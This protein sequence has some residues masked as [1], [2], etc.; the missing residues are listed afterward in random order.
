[1]YRSFTVLIHFNNG[2]YLKIHLEIC[3]VCFTVCTNEH[4]VKARRHID[5]TVVVNKKESSSS[6]R[7]SPLLSFNV[8]PA[9]LFRRKDVFKCRRNTEK[10]E[11]ISQPV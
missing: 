11:Y 2:R 7:F 10:G 5:N 4:F 6:D 1:M 3:V 9:T 8:G